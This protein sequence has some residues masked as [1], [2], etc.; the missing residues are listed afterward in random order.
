MSI[1][2]TQL[3]VFSLGTDESEKTV[4]LKITMGDTNKRLGSQKQK[5]KV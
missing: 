1:Y 4:V 5:F 3:L 2:C